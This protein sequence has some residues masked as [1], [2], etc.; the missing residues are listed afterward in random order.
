METTLGG[1]VLAYADAVQVRYQKTDFATPISSSS[2]AISKTSSASSIMSSLSSAQPSRSNDNVKSSETSVASAKKQEGDGRLSA[3]AYAGIGVAVAAV[4]V[5][6]MC[7]ILWSVRRRKR[8][9]T[10]M[11]ETDKGS[12]TSTHGGN[13]AEMDVASPLSEMD[14]RSPLAEAG[15]RE[16]GEVNGDTRM[17]AELGSRDR[18]RIYQLE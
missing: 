18:A 5:I 10:H 4:L 3:G 13:V 9:D 2:I 12:A 6:A 8:R 7:A 1:S 14:S 15:H 11:K 17:P 16:A